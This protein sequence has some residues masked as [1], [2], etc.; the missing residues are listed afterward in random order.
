LKKYI[1][2]ILTLCL[3]FGSLPGCGF[4]TENKITE[5]PRETLPTDAEPTPYP[6]TVNGTVIGESPERIICLSPSLCEILYEFGEGNRLIGRGSYCDFPREISGVE[7]FGNGISIDTDEIIAVSPDLLLS[8]AP[9]SAKDLMILESAG[10]KTITLPP[11]RDIESFGNIYGTMGVIL[12]GAFTGGETGESV[13]AE[14]SKVFANPNAVNI[15]KFVYITENMASATGDTLES[16]VLSCFG[17]NAA[18]SGTGYVF[19]KEKIIAANPDIVL[20]ND[21][22][23]ADDLLADESYSQ[24]EAVK[25]GRV[26]LI[27]NAYFER[28]S[29]RMAEMIGAVIAEYNMIKG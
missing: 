28:P 13:F 10:V 2:F 11:P 25:D 5:P 23:T 8:S 26:I 6:V 9:V 19:G 27:G 18:K 15:G 4:F 12:Y 17:E 24:L 14:M 7:D 16:S 21:I 3:L 1:A 20:L 22:Y 29:L